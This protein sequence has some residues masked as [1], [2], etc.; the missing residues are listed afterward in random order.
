MKSAWAILGVARGAD[1]DTIRKAYA[2]KLKLTNPEDDPEGFKQLRAA[3]EQALEALRWAQFDFDDEDAGQEDDAAVSDGPVDDARW[4]EPAHGEAAAPGGILT[5]EE[6][7]RI[8]ELAAFNEI[9]RGLAALLEAPER[10]DRAVERQ[11]AAFRQAP[12]LTEIAVRAS[13][14]TWLADLLARTIPQSDA[15]LRQATDLFGWNDSRRQSWSVMRILARLDEWQLIA[16]LGR[17]DHRLH[18][19]W[20]ALR[21]PLKGDLAWRLRTL[22]P[23]VADQVRALL[24]R[25]DGDAPGVAYS[26]DPGAVTRWRAWLAEPRITPGKLIAAPI[27]LAIVWLFA[28]LV[29]PGAWRNMALGLGAGVALFLPVLLLVGERL[30]HRIVTRSPWREH[31]WIAAY[32]LAAVVVLLTPPGTVA[33]MVVA[34]LAMIAGLWI[35][36]QRDPDAPIAMGRGRTI[37]LTLLYVAGVAAVGF[38]R[39]EPSSAL[40][41]GVVLPL[42]PLMRIIA[43]QGLTRWLGAW[44]PLWRDVGLT[45]AV[46]AAVILTA[47]G[48]AVRTHFGTG[49]MDELLVAGLVGGI[50]ILPPTSL[51]GGF[52]S[53]WGKLVHFIVVRGLT[54]ALIATIS[55]VLLNDDR[56]RTALGD[57]LS[58]SATVERRADRLLGDIQRSEPG[59]AR[60]AAGNPSLF[61]A[62]RATVHRDVRERRSENV[63]RDLNA[64]IA[65]RFAVLLPAASDAQLAEELR[66]RL[67]E[68][69]ALQAR[70]PAA[71]ADAD[72]SSLPPALAARRKALVFDVLAHPPAT[73]P[74]GGHALTSRRLIEEAMRKDGLSVPELNRLFADDA[75]PAAR[76]R[77]ALVYLGALAAHTDRDIAATLRAERKAAKRP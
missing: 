28:R 57:D 27:G 21:R 46:V 60:I 19:G 6:Q 7:T 69:Q 67:A 70:D 53:G 49:V 55:G 37:W 24:A 30:R 54:V 17:S 33:A 8:D 40:I 23:G 4:T 41:L 18:R 35:G 39:I 9:A 29:A 43:W 13:A 58:P 59:F 76:C 14:E 50:L 66:I 31:G 72:R 74:G 26:L 48:G 10:D 25:I 32:V 63:I 12:A 52:G 47:T 20:L 62:M 15:I 36:L 44:R 1:R 51:L 64:Q 5:V 22:T 75:G 42:Y 38:L 56:G 77:A 11:F 73:P 16:A 61:A 34:M 68:R 3:Y 71:C 2:R 65:E 45:L